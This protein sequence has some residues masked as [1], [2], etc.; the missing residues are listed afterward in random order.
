VI[1]TDA[2]KRFVEGIP[3]YTANGHFGDYKIIN[4]KSTK[5]KEKN[6]LIQGTIFSSVC[7]L[8]HCDFTA[9]GN[10]QAALS[11]IDF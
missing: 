11:G 7:I 3:C 4:K 1:I 6:V 2:R 9:I 5:C 10:R 8:G